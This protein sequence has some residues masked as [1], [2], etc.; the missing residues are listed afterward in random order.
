MLKAKK[1][2]QTEVAERI[3]K[4]QASVADVSEEWRRH[5]ARESN[6]DG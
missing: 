1:M 3:G 2:T 6:E 4:N 5:E